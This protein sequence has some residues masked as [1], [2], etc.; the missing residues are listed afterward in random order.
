MQDPNTGCANGEGSD[1]KS[2]TE[3]SNTEIKGHIQED[4]G[5]AAR[6]LGLSG[7]LPWVYRW[8]LIQEIDL[9]LPVLGE[10]RVWHFQERN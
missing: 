7:S 4:S 1:V 10:R 6:A 5:Q 9:M 3:V 8:Q 2:Q